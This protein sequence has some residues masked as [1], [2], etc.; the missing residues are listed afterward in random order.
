ML[1]NGTRIGKGRFSRSERR[2][3]QNGK[4]SILSKRSRSV[5]CRRFEFSGQEEYK[6]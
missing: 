6:R 3:K 4:D 5:K 1:P 2:G